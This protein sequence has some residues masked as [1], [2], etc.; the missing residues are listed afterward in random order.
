MINRGHWMPPLR[1]TFMN[2]R[3]LEKANKLNDEH[4]RL[5]QIKNGLENESQ[6]IAAIE[7]SRTTTMCRTPN[8]SLLPEKLAASLKRHAVEWLRTEMTEIQEQFREL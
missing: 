4:E 5:Q 8:I 3:D 2:N 7:F 6:K 1:N